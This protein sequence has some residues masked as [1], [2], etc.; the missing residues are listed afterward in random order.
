MSEDRT[1]DAPRRPFALLLGPAAAASLLLFVDLA[2]GRPE[3]ERTAAVAL[4]MA[5]WW[6]TEAVP[7]AVTSLLPVVLLPLL[8]VMDGQR[9]ASEYFNHVVF[10]FLGGFL[11]ALSIERWGLHRRIALRVLLLFG[12]RPTR[13]LLGFMVATALLSMW[14]SNTATAMMMVTIVLAVV[15]RLEEEEPGEA[16]RR[17]VAGLMIGVAWAASTGG[18]STL[19]G[20]PPNL[21]FARI[22]ER[23]FPEAPKIDFTSWMLF[24]LPLGVLLL[25][26]GWILLSLVFVPRGRKI[27]IDRDHLAAEARALGPV[28]REERAVL[29]VF[30]ALV[31]LW[32]FRADLDLGSIRIP[33][34]SRLLPESGYVNDGVVAVAMALVLFVLP[35]RRSP[36]GRLLDWSTAQRVPW[37]IILLFGGGFALATAFTESGLSEWLGDELKAHAPT[38]PLVLVTTVCFGVTFLTE[39]TSNTATTEMLL[40]VAAG[41]CRSIELN[42]LYLMVPVT[43][44]CS[45]AFMMPVATPPNAIVFG[46]ERVRIAEM[47]ASGV[48]MNLVGLGLIMLVLTV[49]GPPVLGLDPATFP[50]WAR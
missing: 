9:V 37:H 22:F 10:L 12:A 33:G 47:A 44:S 20:T 31:L 17:F 14:I 32:L 49:L 45:C 26:V 8:G 50:D 35:T 48:V 5:I 2:P 34:W 6:I 25:L 19:V 46:S 24:A 27:A 29:A 39:L 41:L 1:T 28:S 30:S 15:R 7:L 3:V 16:T 38:S 21:S 40:P 23:T 43:L 36:S 4:W 13:I 42:P 18:I 11:V